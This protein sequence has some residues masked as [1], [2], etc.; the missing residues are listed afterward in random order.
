MTDR[1]QAFDKRFSLSQQIEEV[2]RELVMRSR[3]YPGFVMRGK[4]RASEADYHM[5]RMR[6]VLHTLERLVTEEASSGG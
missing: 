3:V 5:D 4:M 6:A 2:K 1:T